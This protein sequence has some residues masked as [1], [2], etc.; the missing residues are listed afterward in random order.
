MSADKLPSIA[1]ARLIA[2]LWG[3]IVRPTIGVAKDENGY[4]TPTTLSCVK[5]GWLEP[6]MAVTVMGRGAEY[7]EHRPSAAGLVALE[8]FLGDQRRKAKP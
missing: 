5:A 3:D 6:T 1:Q 2:K 4:S 7:L 8:R